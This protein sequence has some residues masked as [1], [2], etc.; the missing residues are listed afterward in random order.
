MKVTKIRCGARELTGLVALTLA[1]LAAG[2]GGEPAAA[3]PAG[4]GGG[5]G[6][7]G[8]GGSASLGQAGDN[9]FGFV[10]E[11]PP[12]GPDAGGVETCGASPFGADQVEAHVLLVVDKSASMTDTPSGFSTDKWSAVKA[13]LS[14]ALSSVQSDVSF[15][16]ELFPYPDSCN[17]P[18]GGTVNVDVGPGTETVPALLDALDATGPSGGTP[19]AMALAQALEYFTTGAG[20]ALPGRKY[21]LLATDGGPTCNGA[22]SCGTD[23]CVPNL[24]GRC[25][26]AITNCCDPVEAGPGAERGCLDDAATLAEVSA[27]H[28][29]G[30]STFVVGIPG[31]Q[32]FSDSLD[33]FAVAGGVPNSEGPSSYFAVDDPQA[34]T[35][36]LASITSSLVTTCD[37]QLESVPPALN[38]LNVEVDGVVIS[39]GGADGWV[40]DTATSP[41]TVVLQGETCRHIETQ[42]A[43]SVR[44]VYGCPTVQIQ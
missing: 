27:L 5:A 24:E 35:E 15:G 30:V 14:E 19:T 16:L 23:Q 31:S 40:L 20:A 18:T 44:V 9:G 1:A 21:V 36:V 39:Q 37:L 32:L 38:R 11:P 2:C 26:E 17:V 6:Q 7:A 33:A 29:A 34:L 41:P 43:E 42:G 3:D 22:L 12:E 25:P 13:S 4:N 10:S 8:S 28:S